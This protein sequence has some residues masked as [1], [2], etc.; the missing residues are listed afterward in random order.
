MRERTGKSLV[1]RNTAVF[2]LVGF[3]LF[4]ACRS[5]AIDA[6]AAAPPSNPKAALAPGTA[7]PTAP[8]TATSQP[9]RTPRASPSPIPTFTPTATAVPITISGDPRAAVLS[10][11]VP[12]DNALCGIVDLLDFPLDPP[13]ALNVSY[14]GQGFGRFRSRYD[15][16]H[17]GEDWQLVRGRSNLGVPVYAI[18]HG[19]VT[20]AQALGWGT[21]QGVIIIR[22]TFADGSTVLSFYGHLEPD[23]VTLRA[24]DCVVRGQK[25]AR[26]GQPRTPPHLHFEIRTHM[27][28]EPGRGYWPVDPTEAGWLPPSLFIWNNRMASMPGVVWTRPFAA[29]DTQYIDVVNGDTLIL[30]ED[31]QLL[32]LNVADGRLRWQSAITET[33]SSALVDAGR[34]LLYTAD[35]SGEVAAYPLLEGEE[36]TTPLAADPLWQ[37]DLGMMGSP[38]LLPLPGGGLVVSIWED[39]TAVSADG[40]VL[41]RV[42][43][44]QRPFDWLLTDDRLIL[45]VAAPRGPLYSI[46]ASGLQAW[47]VPLNGHPISAG[48]RIWLYDD[49]GLYRLDPEARSADLLYRLPQGFLGLGSIIALPEGGV[50]IA[51]REQADSRLI[52]FNPDGTVEWQRST[53]Q[54]GTGELRLL[55]HNDQ[56]YLLLLSGRDLST[57][58]LLYAIDRQNSVLFHIFIAGTR[59]PLPGG[60]WVVSANDDLLLINVGGGSMAALDPGRAVYLINASAN[61]QATAPSGN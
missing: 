20:Y 40:D 58:L 7:V 44:E 52:A 21:D 47:P 32:G 24:G 4:A 37:V 1:W 45:T 46:T 54:L 50:M 39:L 17:A 6:P 36:G 60:N 8:A 42:K 25:I 38:A 14:G 3:F 13:D 57:Q 34:S 51:H 10:D 35:W 43:L 48:D 16:Y 55:L 28:D 49:E 31:D 59:A 11:P 56:P 26:I 23:S 15:L 2:L 33:V 18:G 29:E 19:R 61:Q 27:P 9:S 5:A 53:A 30:L 22:H 41:W 12:Q